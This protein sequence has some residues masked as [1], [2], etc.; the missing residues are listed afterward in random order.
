MPERT[1]QRR[2]TLHLRGE[3]P[4]TS[5]IRRRAEANLTDGPWQRKL[6]AE[7][8]ASDRNVLEPG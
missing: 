7:D 3:E 6:A 5:R 4:V 8:R 2:A 1:D